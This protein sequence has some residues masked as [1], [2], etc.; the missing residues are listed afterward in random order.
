ML[1]FTAALSFVYFT[2]LFNNYVLLLVW[3]YWPVERPRYSVAAASE[4]S[5]LFTRGDDKDKPPVYS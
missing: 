4:A 3:G 5:A 2:G 1:S